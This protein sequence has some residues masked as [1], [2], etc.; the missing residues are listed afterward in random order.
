[1]QSIYKIPGYIL[2]LLGGFFLSWGGLIIR[3]FETTDIWQILFCRAF[4]MT[5]T[6]GL[7]LIFI[8]RGKTLSVFKQSGYP[9]LIGGVMFSMSFVTYVTSITLSTVANVLFIISTQTVWLALLGYIFLKERISFKTFISILLAIVGI[10]FMVKGSLDVESIFGNLLAL[11]IPINFAIIVLLI[12]KYPNLD[13]IPMLFYA[14]VLNCVYGLIMTDTIFVSTNDVLMGF[15]IGTFQHA[16]GF[17]CVTIGARS[18]PSVVVG[19]LM[20]TETIFG[21]LWVWLFINEVPPLNV[22]IGGCIIL[23]AVILK[24]LEEKLSGKKI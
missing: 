11:T 3:N 17:I 24:S 22:I 19:L 20:L 21:P 23:S 8:Y 18:T 5:L 10:L 16:F 15:L 1:M 14:G 12:R 2:C 13:M 6:I 4:F 9:A 7:F